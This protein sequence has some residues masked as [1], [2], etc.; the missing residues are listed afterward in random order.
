MMNDNPDD[1]PCAAGLLAAT[2]A[3]MTGHAAPDPG[4]R[5]DAAT[6]RRLTARKIASHLCVLRQHP[7]LPPGLRQVAAQ[8]QARWA[9]LAEDGPRQP[10]AQLSLH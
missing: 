6:L 7:D 8:L 10:S 2:L 5:I 4:A 1:R 3:L 9:P